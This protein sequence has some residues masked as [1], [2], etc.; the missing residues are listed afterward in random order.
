MIERIKQVENENKTLKK[1]VTILETIVN[2][3]NEEEEEMNEKDEHAWM[4]KLMKEPL[5]LREIIDEMKINEAQLMKKIEER[6]QDMKKMNVK[7]FF[8]CLHLCDYKFFSFSQ[9]L[10]LYIS[11]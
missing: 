3:K 10:I 1:R 7:I 4:E 8:E 11:F 6:D 5:S 9:K 2:D